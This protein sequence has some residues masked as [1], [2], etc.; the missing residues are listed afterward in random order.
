MRYW[1]VLSLLVVSTFSSA[2]I[3]YSSAKFGSNMFSN[4]VAVGDFDRDGH[5]DVASMDGAN[6]LLTIFH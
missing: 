4:S 2:Q 3:T 5:L 6:S 1:F